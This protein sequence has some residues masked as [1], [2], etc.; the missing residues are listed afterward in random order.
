MATINRKRRFARIAALT[1]TL[2]IAA[3]CLISI[4]ILVLGKPTKHTMFGIYS[5]GVGSSTWRDSIVSDDD[6][7]RLFVNDDPIHWWPTWGTDN[8]RLRQAIRFTAFLP[9]WIPL[10]VCIAA[11]IVVFRRTRMTPTSCG[12]CGYDLTGNVS[13]VCP[14]CGERVVDEENYPIDAAKPHW[15]KPG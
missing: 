9:L 1:I 3:T 2:I 8:A 13:G 11:T 10:V 15:R 14:E 4:W 6:R 5:G 7:L 12:G